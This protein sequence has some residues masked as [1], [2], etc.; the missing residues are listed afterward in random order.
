M[1]VLGVI[2][3]LIFAIAFGTLGIGLIIL[4]IKLMRRG[5][6]G[7]STSKP[8]VF[9]NSKSSN[10]AEEVPLE[11]NAVFNSL[12]ETFKTMNE[13]FEAQEKDPKIVAVT[14]PNCGASCRIPATGGKCDYCESF[15]NAE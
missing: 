14:C 9:I 15:L 6:S 10:A 8:F 5:F 1:E 2:L 12:N 13:M 7:K 4:G 11:I 3:S